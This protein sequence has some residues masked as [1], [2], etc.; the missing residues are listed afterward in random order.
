MKF[1]WNY[2]VLKSKSPW[3]LLSNNINFNKNELVKVQHEIEKYIKRVHH[4]KKCNKTK[5]KQHGNGAVWKKCNLKREQHEKIQH[6][7]K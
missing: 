6:E 5:K 2:D 3:I 1:E 7:K 4:E